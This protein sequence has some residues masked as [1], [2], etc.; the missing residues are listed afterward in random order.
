MKSVVNV[1]HIQASVCAVTGKRIDT[2]ICEYPR[3]VHAQLL[4][5]RVFSKNSSSTRAVPIKKSIQQIENN[6]AQNIW[7]HKKAGMQGSVVKPDSP[8]Y[9]QAQLLHN[10]HSVASM[11]TAAALDS[12]GIHKQN[13]GRY[14]EPFQNIKIVLTSTE[15][16]N[17]DW[18]RADEDAQGEIAELANAIY[19]ARQ[20]AKVI[21]LKAGEWHLPFVHSHRNVAGIL[22][23]YTLEQ[24]EN[25]QKPVFREHTLEDAKKISM[26]ACAQTSYRNLDLSLEKAKDL[27]GKLFGGK[28]VH[29]SPSEHQATPIGDTSA[30]DGKWPMGVTHIDSIGQFWSGN[31]GGFIQ[32]RQLI[33]NHDHSVT[34]RDEEYLESLLAHLDTDCG[35]FRITPDSDIT[36]MNGGTI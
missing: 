24:S 7:T 36:D 16:E 12:I 32:N 31:F 15:W 21:E 3:T 33:P 13:A 22:Q 17:W 11:N 8:L 27:Y 9:A 10:L 4:T 1:Q 25:S 20:E 35:N 14:L 26:S 28:K 19:V 29:A 6:P 30:Y 5:H 23:Y 2:L 18:L 34:L